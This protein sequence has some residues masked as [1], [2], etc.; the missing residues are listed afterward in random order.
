MHLLDINEYI[1]IGSYYQFVPFLFDFFILQNSI[2]NNMTTIIMISIAAPI[3]AKTGTGS[4][5]ILS[6]K[7]SS[8]WL[9][10]VVLLDGLL[11]IE[12]S[13]L[14]SL[15]EVSLSLLF[16]LLSSSTLP[17]SL[18][19]AGILLELA[20]LFVLVMLLFI[21]SGSQEKL[22]SSTLKYNDW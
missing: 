19:L 9:S 22:S 15:F 13:S 7:L 17:S 14:S 12:K 10:A 16:E 8:S 1:Y 6:R 3:L 18:S 21:S 11:S 20:L 4:D 2:N 5:L